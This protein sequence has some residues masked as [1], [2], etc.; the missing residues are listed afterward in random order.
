M[1]ET[2]CQHYLRDK[3]GLILAAQTTRHSDHHKSSGSTA[4]ELSSAPGP[5][6]IGNDQ[7]TQKVLTMSSRKQGTRETRRARSRGLAEISYR[8]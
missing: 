7:S 1:S 8:G 3:Q 5:G 6:A 4:A 2:T